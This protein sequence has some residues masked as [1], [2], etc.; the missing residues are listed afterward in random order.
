VVLT[1]QLSVIAEAFRLSWANMQL[2]MERSKTAPFAA[3]RP[4]VALGITS[5]AVGEGKSTHAL[6]FART[7]ALAGEKV[8][9]VD[10]DL[11]RSGVSRLLDQ[12]C[13]F[14]LRDFLQGQCD[15]DD[16]V[17]IEERSGIYFVPSTP[18]PAAWTSQDIQRF[19]NLVDR[20]K[21]QFAIVIIDLPPVLGLAE[22]IRLSTAADSIMLII[23]WARTER[24][25]VQ[26]AVD[27]LRNAGVAV[28]AAILNDIDLRAQQR[29]GHRDHSLVY[30]DESLYRTASKSPTPRAPLPAVA[31]AADAI[32]GSAQT[33]GPQR[34]RNRSDFP[35]DDAK[36]APTGASDIERLYDKYIG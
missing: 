4:G 34:N 15:A 21:K 28:N 22:T 20:L 35:R 14:T 6:A 31:S 29:R 11:R 19:F 18:V 32:F 17:T 25:F 36:V 24:Q 2:S 16:V 27:A 10:A 9:L 13:R 5:A 1:D 12:N 3:G 23:R 33:R 8:V 7:A 26:F 30:A